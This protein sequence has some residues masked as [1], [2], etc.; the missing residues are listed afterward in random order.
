M[1]DQTMQ[2]IINRPNIQLVAIVATLTL[3][4]PQ[5][6]VVKAASDDSE[7][8]KIKQTQ[9]LEEVVVSA[10]REKAVFERDYKSVA[11][12]RVFDGPYGNEKFIIA[13]GQELK[14]RGEKKRVF[15]RGITM[16]QSY[17]AS[18]LDRYHYPIAD[19]CGIDKFNFYEGGEFLALGY[20]QG[21]KE[22]LLD[23]MT[24]GGPFSAPGVWGPYDQIMGKRHKM[25]MIMGDAKTDGMGLVESGYAIGMK[26]KL[27]TYEL[28]QYGDNFS[29][30]IDNTGQC[31]AD[32]TDEEAANRLISG[33]TN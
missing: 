10:R 26:A 30:A 12:K 19:E 27:P 32:K 2:T 3:V 31:L 33:K 14:N 18:S 9:T 13:I 17:A 4:T 23:V 5:T 11:G 7:F 25:K 1:S 8:K 22:M 20:N 28:Q 29:I 6:G 24:G 16:P 21:E 15:T